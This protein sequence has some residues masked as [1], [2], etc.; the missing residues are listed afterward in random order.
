MIK[1]MLIPESPEMARAAVAG[2]VDRLFIDLERAGKFER[3]GGGTWISTHTLEDVS[4]YR[5]AFPDTEM[6]VRIDPWN[7]TADGIVDDVI[8][9]GTNIIM[10]PMIEDVAHV[11][12]L[13]EAAEGRAKVI[14]LIETAHSAER[15]E[16]ICKAGIDEIYVGLNDLH[17]QLGLRFMFEPL[18]NGLVEQ[19]RDVA[20]RHGKP[21]GFGGMAQIGHGDL[22]AEMILGE[23]VRLGS[24]SVILS[25]KFKGD[26]GADF[27]WKAHIGQ[28]RD[29]E[30]TYASRSEAEVERDRL[31]VADRIS[32]VA[33]TMKAAS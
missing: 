19:L 13:V 5:E 6:L 30:R 11:S 4:A 2:G 7:R 12:A 15:I 29:L 10:L 21:F 22:P 20:R 33:A 31:A 14:P 17:R 9:R 25:R 32:A 24:T 1:L 26:A 18:G 3:Q 28:I 16:T 8:G 27:D 23:H